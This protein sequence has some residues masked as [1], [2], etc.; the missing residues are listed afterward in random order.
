MFSIPLR[1]V[2]DG[3]GPKFLM[4]PMSFW[5]SSGRRTGQFSLI[6]VDVG[7]IYMVEKWMCFPVAR[8]RYRRDY[9]AKRVQLETDRAWKDEVVQVDRKVR[10]SA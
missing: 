5:I 6:S 8:R 2:D 10:V 3:F 9:T 7:A 4:V 1:F